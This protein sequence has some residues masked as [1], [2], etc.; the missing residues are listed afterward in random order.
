WAL[1]RRT[2]GPARAGHRM[3]RRAQGRPMLSLARHSGR[4]AS[5]RIGRPYVRPPQHGIPAQPTPLIGREHEVQLVREQLARP[6]VRLLTLTGPA[7]TG[8]TRLAL[9]VA[10]ELAPRVRDGA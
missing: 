2:A 3:T 7:G 4:R 1:R 10:I 9:Q 6:E 8:K 5:A